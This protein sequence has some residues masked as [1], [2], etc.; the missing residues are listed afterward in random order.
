MGMHGIAGICSLKTASRLKSVVVKQGL[1]IT[2]NK[3]SRLAVLRTMRDEI[4]AEL[5]LLPQRNYAT[6]VA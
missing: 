2:A 4:L 5:G 1:N 3:S 6:L